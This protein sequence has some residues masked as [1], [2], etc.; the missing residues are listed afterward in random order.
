MDDRKD[1]YYAQAKALWIA[2]Q[3]IAQAT[4]GTQR[5]SIYEELCTQNDTSPIQNDQDLF[6]LIQ[7]LRFIIESCNSVKWTRGVVDSESFRRV[8][9]G[10]FSIRLEPL[11]RETKDA[12]RDEMR[13][14]LCNAFETQ[15][16]VCVHLVGVPPVDCGQG[17][18]NSTT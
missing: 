15:C 1:T 4:D 18:P 11:S 7:S 12:I 6:K 3:S 13:C 9:N 16:S 8:L 10:T 5:S 17:F 2:A 14:T